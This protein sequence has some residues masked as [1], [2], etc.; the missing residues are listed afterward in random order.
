[1]IDGGLL[2]IMLGAI[3]LVVIPLQDAIA[4]RRWA[5][6]ATIGQTLRAAVPMAEPTPAL[7]R[8][9][10]EADVAIARDE[11]LSGVA[12]VAEIYRRG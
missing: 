1:M 8:L 6:T 7:D 3:A 10:I 9:V 11:L 2:L 4:Y 5:R 12:G